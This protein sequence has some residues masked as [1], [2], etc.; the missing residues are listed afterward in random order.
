MNVNASQDKQAITEL[1]FRHD[2]DVTGRS[3]D[4]GRDHV[5]LARIARDTEP[6]E[7]LRRPTHVTWSGSVMNILRFQWS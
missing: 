7:R 1:D 2:F 6:D 3:A 4:T 5:A